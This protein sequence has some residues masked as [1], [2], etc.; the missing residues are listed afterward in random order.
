MPECRGEVA[1]P[2][3]ARFGLDRFSLG[4]AI[5][6]VALVA[7]GAEALE[8]LVR[9]SLDGGRV[10]LSWTDEAHPRDAAERAIAVRSA[11]GR[12]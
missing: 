9:E 12:G 7:A 11:E 8:R 5:G 3:A 6:A 4:I 1:P 10:K 2:P